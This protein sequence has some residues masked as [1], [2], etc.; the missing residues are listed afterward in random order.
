MDEKEKLQYLI[1]VQNILSEK[2]NV[3]TVH[4]LIRRLDSHSS[5]QMAIWH[6]LN[7][8]ESPLMTFIVGH[9]RDIVLPIDM[10][11]KDRVVIWVTKET[12]EDSKR[13]AELEFT[14]P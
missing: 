6:Q 10:K 11:P 4:F 3:K 2:D 9:T 12:T 1:S 8:G 7:D 5:D 13:L 14:L